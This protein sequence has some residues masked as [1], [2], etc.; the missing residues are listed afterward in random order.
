GD[1]EAEGRVA[2]ENPCY[3]PL[4]HGLQGMANG[5]EVCPVDESG[6]CLPQHPVKMAWMT[7][8]RQYP[9]TTSMSTERRLAW[10]DYSGRNQSWLIEDDYDGEYHYRKTPLSTVFSMVTQRYPQ[11]QQ[12]VILVGSFSKLM[13]RTLRIGYL[14]AP[15]SLVERLVEEQQKMGSLA[16]VPIQPALADFLGHR[17]FASHLRRMRRCYQQ[18]RDFLHQLLSQQLDDWLIPQLPDGGM[19]LLAHLRPGT[20]ITD[21]EIEQ[22]M[23]AD[24]MNALAL[25]RHYYPAGEQGLILGY[26][27]T[28]EVDLQRGVGTLR[29]LF[30][31]Y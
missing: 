26:S 10:L 1:S 2:L 19:H 11:E 27:G 5:V 3:P 18:R 21:T 13:F 4:R 14:I 6:M 20:M 12:R 15:P 7:P 9:L 16:S 31:N 22:Q 30:V 8:A 23:A 17:R 29:N 25:S 24:G 28:P